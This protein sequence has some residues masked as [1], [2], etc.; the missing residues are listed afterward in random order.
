MKKHQAAVSI[1]E[2][3]T[4]YP[5]AEVSTGQIRTSNYI[6]PASTSTDGVKVCDEQGQVVIS[7]CQNLTPPPK[8]PTPYTPTL[9][10]PTPSRPPATGANKK[11]VEQ[12]ETLIN[13]L[14]MNTQRQTLEQQLAGFKGH[15]LS[16]A[17]KKALEALIDTLKNKPLVEPNINI[18]PQAQASNSLL[19]GATVKANEPIILGDIV[20]SLN[21]NS[22]S[23]NNKET[24]AYVMKTTTPIQSTTFLSHKTT[25]SNMQTYNLYPKAK[26][27]SDEDKQLLTYATDLIEQAYPTAGN[28]SEQDQAI[29]TSYL[30]RIHFNERALSFG[31]KMVVMNVMDEIQTKLKGMK[32]A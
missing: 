8:A 15:L 1:L 10:I 18:M 2:G 7:V 12:A 27:A 14:P 24:E 21:L 23:R 28:L 5:G 16:V 30:K 19:D 22:A 32:L 3:A 20:T 31:D 26:P 25:L 4:I 29:K 11:L 13:A 6:A 9:F 17:D